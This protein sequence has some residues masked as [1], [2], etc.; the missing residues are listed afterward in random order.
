MQTAAIVIRYIDSG[1]VVDILTIIDGRALQFCNRVINFADGFA[2]MRA[3]GS[4]TRPML[5]HPSRRTQVRKSMQ[6]G[7]VCAGRG[8]ASTPCKKYYKQ[9]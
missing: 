9:K 2:F 8:L 1:M 4:I 6:V 7:G 3:D 5:E